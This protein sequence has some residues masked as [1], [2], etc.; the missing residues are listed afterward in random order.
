M[1]QSILLEETRRTNALLQKQLLW[2]R[3]NATGVWGE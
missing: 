3:I 2:S 1:E